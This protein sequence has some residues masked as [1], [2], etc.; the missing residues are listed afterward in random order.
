VT[1]SEAIEAVPNR[2]RRRF[3]FSLRT[4]LVLV[5]L[6]SILLALCVA[7]YVAPYRRQARAAVHFSR[8][9]GKVRTE[10]AAPV[11]L[12]QLLGAKNVYQVDLAE[13]QIRD[14]DL[15]QLE[16]FEHLG[17]LS[18]RKTKVTDSGIQHLKGLTNL[19]ALDLSD[20]HTTDAGL[21][22]LDL[23]KLSDLSVSNT[24]I[25]DAGL[26]QLDDSHYIGFLNLSGTKVTNIG[27]RHIEGIWALTM[28]DLSA[29][30]V[31][32]AGDAFSEGRG[33]VE[34]DPR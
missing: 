28:L 3:Q 34:E 14:S 22:Y 9:G 1:E 5:T 32:D 30:Q 21:R 31:T 19:L 6:A 29:T 10:P 26:Q 25:T 4:L 15:E 27:L 16:K 11:W 24:Q 12:A 17:G 18:L 33:M 8:L 7:Y 23:T 20:T 13:T 2:E